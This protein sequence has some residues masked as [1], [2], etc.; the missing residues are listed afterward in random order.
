[1]SRA[2]VGGSTTAWRRV[3]AAVLLAN[4][5]ENGGRCRLAVKSVCTGMAEQVHH[6]KGKQYGDDIR[7]L[8]AVCRAC[9][10]HVGDPN[11]K[12]VQP[13]PRSRW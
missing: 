2:W 12:F 5:N 3:R 10:L 6:T 4:E 11:R 9:N 7:Y 8:V 1:M 13:K